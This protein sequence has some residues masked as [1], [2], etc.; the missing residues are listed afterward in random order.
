MQ[1]VKILHYSPE[2]DTVLFVYFMELICKESHTNLGVSKPTQTV[3]FHYNEKC[4]RAWYVVYMVEKIFLCGSFNIVYNESAC[5]NMPFILWQKYQERIQRRW[6]TLRPFGLY[7]KHTEKQNPV[8]D[9]LLWPVME[10]NV[11][12]T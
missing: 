6:L 11:N 5:E 12:W 10:D 7:T 8:E 4:N 3:V 9:C 2:V 1:H